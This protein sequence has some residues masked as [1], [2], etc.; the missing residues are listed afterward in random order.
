MRRTKIVAT[1]GPATDGLATQ[2]VRAGVDVFR[3]NFSHGSRQ[4]HAR[5]ITEVRA[6]A[7]A[8][9][10]FCA[11]LADL[12]GP[13]IRIGG[14]AGAAAVS[15][16]PGDSFAV[17]ASLSAD[18]GDSGQVGC[19]YARLARDVGRGDEL[20]LGD[21][22]VSLRVQGKAG[23][24]VECTVMTGGEVRSGSGLNKRFG[25]LS[26]PALS[27]KDLDDLEFACGRGADYIGVSFA[28]TAA[29]MDLARKHLARLGARSRLVAK[30]ERAEV[31]ADDASLDSMILAS[32]SVMVARGDLGI[33]IG[34]AALMAV[35]KR[36][37]RRARTLNRSVITATQMMESM[38][39]SPRPTRAEVMDAANAVVDGT[40]AVM[41]SGETAVGRFPVEVVRTLARVVEGAEASEG[42]Q[43]RIPDRPKCARIDEAV[44]VAAMTVAAHLDGVRA[45]ICMTASGNT[46]RLMSRIYSRFPIYA[47][48][49][50]E[51]ALARVALFRGVQPVRFSTAGLGPDELNAAAVALLRE[52]GTV[53]TGDRVILSHGG[54]RAAQGGTNTL[55]ILEVP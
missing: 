26:A 14:F 50:D 21:G 53:R 6:A 30:I 45:V 2:L 29:D 39:T 41:L 17:D 7:T 8:C 16:A 22:I 15:L 12:Q 48:A 28:R 4:D 49:A 44:A 32:D 34:D 51:R 13:K 25:G 55:R 19:T 5:R 38:I 20:V 36:I 35:Q 47:L 33:E 27:G 1:L 31:V 42:L 18:E 37:I 23:K 54:W 24:R 10:R 11:I 9:G 40:D 43:S 52:D 46:P 3:L